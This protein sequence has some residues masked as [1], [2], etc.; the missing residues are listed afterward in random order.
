MP[1]IL[2]FVVHVLFLAMPFCV[3]GQP[4]CNVYLY[5][6]DTAQYLA[7]KS[8]ER[9]PY[10]QY[11]RQYQEQ[12]DKAL[13]ICP[14]FA[15][16][17]RSK[18]TAYLKSG[19]FLMW[20]YLIDK[21]VQYDTLANIGYRGACR[22][23][24]FR[25]YKGAISDIA[26]LEKRYKRIGIGFTASGDYHLIVI[27]AICY[28]A[29]GDKRKAIEILENLFANEKYSAGLFDYYQLGVTY[30]QVQDYDNALKYFDKQ[31]A[32]NELAENRYYKAKIAKIKKNMPL[33]QQEKNEA[34]ALYKNNKN[35][36]DPYTEHFN[37][38][39]L[40]TIVSE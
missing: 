33:Y 27:K 10:Y 1:K 26:Y 37:K 22:H 30:F 36:L 24:F 19:D 29:L 13:E 3:F 20:K 14:Y 6:K 38:V 12:Y 21:A 5:N 34:I 11:T 16:A 15:H 4:N 39:Y 40:S 8:V 9:V 7:C 28:S 17:Y 25:D 2:Q 23:Q 31:S 18:S 32:E 35:M